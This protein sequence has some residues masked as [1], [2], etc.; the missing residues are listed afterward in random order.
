[1]CVAGSGNVD[2][3]LQRLC[4]CSG[5]LAAVLLDCCSGIRVCLAKLSGTPWSDVGNLWIDRGVWLV[6]C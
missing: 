6:C 4:C 2:V 5:L 1:M 3:L